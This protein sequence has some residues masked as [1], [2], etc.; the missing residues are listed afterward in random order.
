MA[1][2]LCKE[3]EKE[4]KLVHLRNPFRSK[5]SLLMKAITELIN[6]EELSQIIMDEE[7]ITI[8]DKRII[9]TIFKILG[10]I[11]LNMN[12]NQNPQGEM[13]EI[14]R[15]DQVEDSDFERFR[16]EAT[17]NLKMHMNKVFE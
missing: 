14:L 7:K 8:R 10:M 11:N 5:L 9:V 12:T 17:N 15:L 6:Y 13:K 16:F 3:I 1:A 2:D 4:F